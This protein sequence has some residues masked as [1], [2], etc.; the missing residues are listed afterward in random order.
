MFSR[1]TIAIFLGL[2]VVCS[3]ADLNAQKT[4]AQ[5]TGDSLIV[6]K[7]GKRYTIT[8]LAD[9]NLWI[10]SNLHLKIPDSYCY[11]N[12]K[13]NCD[14]YGRLYTW[15]AANQACKLL[16]DG[17]RLP[18]DG[19]WNQLV[20]QYGKN[21]GDSTGMRK[22]A[23]ESLLR[24]GSSGFEA[25]LGGARDLEAQFGRLEAH[26]FYWTETETDS[27]SAIYYNFAKGSKAL[28]RQDGGEKGRA[29]SVRCIKSLSKKLKTE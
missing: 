7:D 12:E 1:K 24:N 20:I 25:V 4:G 8:L 27:S 16:G 23:F 15:T 3:P 28:Y 14:Q 9:G 17:W 10:G 2:V 26:G 22:K 13:N 5:E 29:F 18:T 11:E 21:S 19:E 6:D